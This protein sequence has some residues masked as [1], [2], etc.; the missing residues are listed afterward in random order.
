MET[1]EVESKHSR[2]RLHVL[3]WLRTMQTNDAYTSVESIKPWEHYTSAITI[4]MKVIFHLHCGCR[5]ID[6]FVDSLV[7][8]F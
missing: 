6:S 2:L 7:L 1:E 8:D 4:T 3:K 5:W